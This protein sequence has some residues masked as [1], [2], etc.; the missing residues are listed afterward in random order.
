M[1]KKPSPMGNAIQLSMM[2]LEAQSVIT[3]R[4]MG[5]AGMWSVSP[6]ENTRMITEKMEAMVKSA[7]GA[8]RVT[9]RGGS[10]DEITA[11]AIAPVRSATRANSKRL[12]KSGLKSV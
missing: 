4:L 9:L 11:A 10:A 1:R 12:K 8:S 5:M 7:A 3:M 2:M 6:Q